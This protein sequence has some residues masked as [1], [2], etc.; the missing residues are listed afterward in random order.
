MLEARGRAHLEAIAGRRPY[1]REI[2][3]LGCYFGAVIGGADEAEAHARADRLLYACLERGLSFKIGG[4]DVATL[5]PPLTIPFE[6]FDDAF[7]ILDDALGA[8]G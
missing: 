5:C 3:A 2:R 7:A 1:L 6:A 4:G 8:V